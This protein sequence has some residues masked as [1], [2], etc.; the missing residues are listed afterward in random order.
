MFANY[1]GNGIGVTHDNIHVEYENFAFINS[2]Q[3]L[4]FDF[5][6]YFVLGLYLDKIIPSDFGQSLKPWFLCTPSYYKC[7]RP[8]RNRMPAVDMGDEE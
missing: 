6:L 7:C 2:L 1:E 3:M 4:L 5:V 8:R